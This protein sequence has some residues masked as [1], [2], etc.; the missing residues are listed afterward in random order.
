VSELTSAWLHDLDRIFSATLARVPDESFTEP[1][2][3]PGW[4]R[5]HVI[6]HI[7]F[8]ALALCR[9]VGWARTGIEATMY[10]SPAQRAEEIERGAV[11]PPS[12][13]RDLAAESAERFTSDFG[14]LTDRERERI[15][16]TAQGRHIPAAELAWLRCRELGVHAVDL[17]SGTTFEDLPNGFVDTL[18]GEII[19]KRL[20]SGEGP[21][22]AGWLTGRQTTEP[23]DRWL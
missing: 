12:E 22:L 17:G 13:L 2:A 9:L 3:L 16:V 15:I 20:G 7:H 23:L 21:A 5:G 6:A 14:R 18:V 10:A 1:I 4:T 19:A 8:N 11:S